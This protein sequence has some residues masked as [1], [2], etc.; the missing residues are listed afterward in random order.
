MAPVHTPGESVSRLLLSGG[1]E[2]LAC[3]S[4]RVLGQKS[5]AYVGRVGC[6]WVGRVYSAPNGGTWALAVV[7][8][9][10]TWPNERFDLF[11]SKSALYLVMI[12]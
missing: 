3:Y 4:G 5:S 10:F 2:Q 8:I 6:D 9:A 1:G 7:Y 12:Q 11:R